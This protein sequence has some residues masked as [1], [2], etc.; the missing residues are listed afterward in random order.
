MPRGKPRQDGTVVKQ[1]PR[2]GT[3]LQAIKKHCKAC[4]GDDYPKNCTVDGCWLWPWRFG[5]GPDVARHDGKK[6]DPKELIGRV[7]E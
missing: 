1:G 5:C 6:V 3:P 7:K 4:M 2:Y